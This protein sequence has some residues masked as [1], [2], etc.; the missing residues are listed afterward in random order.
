M[1]SSD[2]CGSMVI[3]DEKNTENVSASALTS[4]AYVSRA[5]LVEPFQ[6]Q[7]GVIAHSLVGP[8]HVGPRE[9]AQLGC[10]PFF[11]SQA[12]KPRP[13]GK[14]NS[15]RCTDWSVVAQSSAQTRSSWTTD[16]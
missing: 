7:S 14:K 11:P 10:G 3:L 13:M 16:P 2:V 8:S 1:A 4:L 6:C 5:P 12:K 15:K 9:S